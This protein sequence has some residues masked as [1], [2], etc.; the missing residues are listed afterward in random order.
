MKYFLRPYLKPV[1]TIL[2]I[3]A[4]AGAG[5]GQ[6]PQQNPVIHAWQLRDFYTEKTE[7]E[8]DTM[9]TAFQLHNP[10]FRNN[11][12]SSH[13]GNAG[14]AAMPDFFPDRRLYSDFFFIDHFRAYLRHPSET[15]YYN[16]RRP[17]SL[18][19]FSTGGPRTKNEKILSILHTQN[20]NPDFNIGFRYFNINSDGQYQNQRAVTNALSFFSSYDLGNYQFHANLNFNSARVFES[21]GLTDDASLYRIDFDTRDHAVRLMNARNG[22]SNNSFFVSQSFHPFLILR[23]DTLPPA[24]ASWLQRFEIY[25]VLQYDQYRRT[26]DDSNPVS[27]FYPDIF[28]NNRRTF[29]S[30]SYRSLTNKLMLE[31]PEFSRGLVNFGAKAGVMN[32]LIRGSHNI[33]PDTLF[34]FNNSV[35]EPLYYFLEMPSDLIITDRHQYSRGSNA[36]IASARGGIGDV[37]G[38][39]G[40]GNYFFQ[41]FKAG[42]Y[43]IQAGISFDLFKGRNQSIFEGSLRQKETT[44]SLF[45]KSFYSNHFAWNNNFRRIGESSLQ[46]RIRMPGRGLVASIDFNLLNNYIYFNHNAMPVQYSDV[47]PVMS[48]AAHKDFRLWRFHFRNVAKY[49]VSGNENILPLPAI[50][51]YQSTWFEQT[52]IRGMMTLQIGF[53]ARYTTAYYGYAYQPATSQFYLQNERKLGNYPYL[54]AFVN[55]KHKRARLFFKT[56]H[57]NADWLAPEYFSV[58]HYPGN[59]R[60]YKF[61]L[62]WTF[63]N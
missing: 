30:L 41:G 4:T 46:G 50:S 3:V 2:L 1:F 40:R 54:D 5:S 55:V 43:D 47:I 38:I 62:S 6:Q 63:Y 52:L 22:V 53:D 31:L 13:L 44:P 49:Q 36:L 7:V 19:D 59:H 20:V 27:G 16:T 60:V 8:I 26:Y 17:F 45:L 14:L 29:D 61:G 48:I 39:W 32:E 15:E 35:Q 10:V 51:L 12:S 33:Y 56:E 21:G 58:L 23:N 37:F 18:I 9:I 11:I 34:L 24:D 42:E 28:I 25:H 57:F